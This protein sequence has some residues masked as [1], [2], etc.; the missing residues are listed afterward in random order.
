LKSPPTIALS[1]KEDYLLL[2]SALGI[3]RVA[4]STVLADFQPV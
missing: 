4:T 3:W 2:F 1:S